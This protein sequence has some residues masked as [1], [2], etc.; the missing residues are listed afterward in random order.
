MS[1]T[2]ELDLL[3]YYVRE[4][5]YLRKDGKDFSQRF[6]KVAARLDLRESE[7]LDPHTERLIESVAFLSARIHRDIDRE[8]SEVASGLLANLCPS[9]IQPIPSTT[10]VKIDPCNFEGKVTAGINVPKHTI[11]STK[12]SDDDE[13]KF[14]TVWDSKIMALEVDEVKINDDE[15]LCLKIST[16]Q[17]TDLSEMFLDKLSF[18]I[19]GDWS[20]SSILFEALSHRV[21]SLYVKDTHHNKLKLNSSAIRFQGFQDDEIALPQAPGSHPAYSLLQEYFSFPK[22]FFFFELNGLS[23][24]IFRGKELIIEIDLGGLPSKVRSVEAE[25]LKLNCIPVINIF[26]KI[27]EPITIDHRNY[28]YLL[29]PD[30]TRELSTEIHSVINITAS[31]P[32]SK[33]PKLIPQFSA[34][35][36]SESIDGKHNSIYWSYSRKKSLRKDFSGTDIFL[37]FVDK[38]NSLE[39]PVFPVLYAKILCTNRRL[40]EQLP[41]KALLTG[42]GVSAGLTINCLYEPSRQRDPPLGSETIWKLTSLLSLNH[43]SLLTGETSKTLVREILSLFASDKNSDVDQIRGVLGVTAKGITRK[44][45]DDAW[46]GFCRGVEIQI[47]LDPEA[48]VGSS[49]ILFSLIMARFFSLYTTINSFISLSVVRGKEKIVEWP[50]ISGNQELI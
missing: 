8:Y 34:L 27:S 30:R 36:D 44:F 49:M 47:Q 17:N 38:N 40:A 48:F 25:N 13:C 19:A 12:T 35:E 42:E 31:E 4:L 29:I 50:P 28:E 32:G 41:V 20:I 16:K 39:N 1:K 22:K 6:P 37:N 33:I 11:L 43:H 10:V 9:L 3:D 46:R 45:S 26:T 24:K 7:S 18:H 21:K 2:E 15:N 14:R 23:N 5:D